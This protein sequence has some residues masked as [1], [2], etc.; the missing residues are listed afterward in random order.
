MGPLPAPT[1]GIGFGEPMDC[2]VRVSPP[3]PTCPRLEGTL[4]EPAAVAAGAAA[5]S[6][7]VAAE[8]AIAVEG[9]VILRE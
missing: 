8:V 9:M 1:S 2:G 7:E 4:E 6:V 3:A 5:A